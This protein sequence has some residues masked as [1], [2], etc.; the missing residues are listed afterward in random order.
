MYIYIYIYINVYIYVYIYINLAA[1]AEE[2]GRKTECR[3]KRRVQ[4]LSHCTQHR[5]GV[6]KLRK[7]PLWPEHPWIHPSPHLI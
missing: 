5:K 4:C 3:S 1:I 6:S 2:P 7:P